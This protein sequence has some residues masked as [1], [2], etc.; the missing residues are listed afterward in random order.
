M[1]NNCYTEI[2]K[3]LSK[4]KVKTNYNI[5]ACT[6]YKTGG[7]ADL[8][9]EPNSIEE[10]LFSLDTLKGVCPYYFIGGGNNLLVSDKGVRGAVIST[11][12]LTNVEIKGNLYIAECGASLS[13]VIEDMRLNSLSGL[14]FTVGIPATVGGAVTMNAG[15]Y[16]KSVGDLVCYVLTDNGIIKKSDSNFSYRNSVFKEQNLAVLK[17]CFSLKPSEIDVIEEK[18]LQ[19]KGFRKNPKGKNCGSVFKNDGYFAGKVIDECN[20]KGFKIGGARV[21]SEHAN[22]IIADDTATS[23]DIYDLIKTIKEKV[24]EKKQIKLIEEICYLGDF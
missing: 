16:G 9:I 17:V 22:F 2:T 11:K 7:S 13:K 24:F 3:K 20:L 19:Y 23:K 14:E 15:C 4:L 6:R 12:N 10:L 18:L 21:S 8:Y 5:S 1:L